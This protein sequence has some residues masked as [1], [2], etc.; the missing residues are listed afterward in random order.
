[1]T[2]QFRAV[3]FDVD[4]ARRN[5]LRFRPSLIEY[6]PYPEAIEYIWR[7]IGYVFP[8]R[9]PAAFPAIDSPVLTS[10]LGIFDRYCKEAVELIQSR[11]LNGDSQINIS[12][13]DGRVEANFVPKEV[14][15]GFSTTFRQFYGK[16]E[17]ARFKSVHGLLCQVAKEAWGEQGDDWEQLMLWNK[18]ECQLRS[19]SLKVLVGRRLRQ[20]T[21]DTE[22]VA[23]DY[24]PYPEKLISLYISAD[25]IH[26]DRQRDEL[27]ALTSTPFDEAWQR[28]RFE[29]AVAGLAHLYI[30]FAGVVRA[31]LGL[32][33]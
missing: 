11:F 33:D 12:F 21:G 31:V 1:M 26:W 20:E 2:D 24:P 14:T 22:P 17:P 10:N 3:G 18:V 9:D 23:D 32:A 29:E 30:G 4:V 25:L 5:P 16:A 19:A 8:F 27:N 15:R 7:L 13:V 28:Y 6:A